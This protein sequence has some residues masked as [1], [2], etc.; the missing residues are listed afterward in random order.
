MSLKEEYKQDESPLERLRG[1]LTPFFMLAEI[2]ERES[3]L[4]ED[5]PMSDFIKNLAHECG[6]DAQD[7]VRNNIDDAAAIMKELQDFKAKHDV[8]L[9]MVRT[10]GPFYT[11]MKKEDYDAYERHA[12]GMDELE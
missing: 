8:P 5:C 4:L 3:K 1:R 11:Y 2:I 10:G 7:A 12:S 9:G 6:I